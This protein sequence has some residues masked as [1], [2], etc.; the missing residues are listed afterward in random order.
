M[1][2]V[3]AEYRTDIARLAEDMAK[4]DAEAARR[5]VQ[6]TEREATARWRQTAIATA[7]ILAGI[8]VATTV[9]ISNLPRQSRSARG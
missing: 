6:R 3:Q 2:T 1:N 9:I 7:V 5:E 4:R 8:G